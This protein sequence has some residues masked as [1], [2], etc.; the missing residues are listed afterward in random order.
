MIYL[1]LFEPNHY[2]LVT[3]IKR[4]NMRRLLLILILGQ[5]IHLLGADF[6][7]DTVKLYSSILSENRSVLVFTPKEFKSTDSASIMYMPDGEYAKSRFEHV[8]NKQNQQIIGIGIINTDRRRELL[9]VHQA[10]DFNEFIVKELCKVIEANYSV[11]E[12]ILYGHS[13]GGAFTIYSMLNSP[14]HFDKYIA[15]SP[16]PIMNLIDDD[17]YRELNDNLQT[18]IKFYISYGSRD[19]RQVKKW[20]SRLIE[21]LSNIKC[22]KLR[23]KCEIFEGE[24]HNTSDGF[25]IVSGMAF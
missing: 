20:A 5:S 4:R 10:D 15:S 9:P 17:L 3:N 7:V 13:F 22:D 12:K 23:W 2:Q 21:N 18:E 16:T 11:R 25:S 24:N 6:K 8:A 1:P 14:A 19:I